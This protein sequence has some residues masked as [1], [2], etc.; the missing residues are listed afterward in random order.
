MSDA[1]TDIAT[2]P[3]ASAEAEHVAAEPIDGIASILRLFWRHNGGPWIKIARVLNHVIAHAVGAVAFMAIIKVVGFFSEIIFD[4][5][6][7]VWFK[8]T[9]ISLSVDV[10]ILYADLVVFMTFIVV[11]AVTSVRE[12]LK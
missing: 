12:I 3:S 9:P 4:S 10:V 11:G 7:L 5:T 8:N 6:G 1:A 2:G